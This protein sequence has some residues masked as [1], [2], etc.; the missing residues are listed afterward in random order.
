METEE[1]G[2]E[3]RRTD[4]FRNERFDNPTAEFGK[5]RYFSARGGRRDRS[6]REDRGNSRVGARGDWGEGPRERDFN[7]YRGADKGERGRA[8]KGERGRADN[9]S[10]RL[11][12]SL[13]DPTEVPRLGN[14]FEVCSICN[15]IRM[16]QR[17]L[18]HWATVIYVKSKFDN[19]EREKQMAKYF[20]SQT[21]WY[22]E[23]QQSSKKRLHAFQI[24]H[25]LTTEKHTGTAGC[26]T[27]RVTMHQTRT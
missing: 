1:E 12:E 3:N 10:Q 26:G 9:Y 13:T 7:Q 23:L 25:S 16:L 2:Q 18:H 19:L 4:R 8:D 21:E 6:W 14:F 5:D 11:F 20:T 22:E 15:D 27:H 24:A 17:S